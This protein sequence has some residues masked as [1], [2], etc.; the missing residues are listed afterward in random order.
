VLGASSALARCFERALHGSCGALIAS[1]RNR[2]LG[3]QTFTGSPTPI[4]FTNALRKEARVRRA[5]DI[6]AQTIA[7]ITAGI[8]GWLSSHEALYLL[9]L[10]GR[11]PQTGAIVEIGSFQGKSTVVLAHASKASGREKV[12][13]ID[14]YNG[15]ASQEFHDN[16]RR[17]E[18][19]DHVIPIVGT[20]D[21]VASSWTGRVRLL[22]VDGKHTFDQAQRDFRNW[23]PFVV[24][25]GIVAFHDTYQWPGVRQVIDTEV[26]P[27]DRFALIGTVDSIAAFR[28]VPRL[29][30]SLRIRRW[31]MTAGRRLYWMN[32]R[33]ALPGD[34]RR[35][36]KALLRSLSRDNLN[37]LQGPS[38][39]PVTES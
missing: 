25:G 37:S 34:V 27:S 5:T 4:D 23:G 30:T 33:R 1:N 8:E 21:D 3:S 31:L 26:I 15:G 2:A 19:A 16:L 18:V 7:D 36:V 14:P 32:G 13:A 11:G 10:A 6:E 24:E 29:T 35:G 20:S 12:V 39:S 9:R 17:A 38:C 22:W 28:K